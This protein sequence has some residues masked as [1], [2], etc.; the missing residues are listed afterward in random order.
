[1]KSREIPSSWCHIKPILEQ[2]VISTFF[3]I[4][5]NVVLLW[6]YLLYDSL[7]AEL[8]KKPPAGQEIPVWF[9]GREDPLEKG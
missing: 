5:F 2:Q 8:V 3:I 6:T 7:I 9:L 4:F 1:M